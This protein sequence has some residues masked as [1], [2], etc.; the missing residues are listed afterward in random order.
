MWGES[1]GAGSSGHTSARSSDI[2]TNSR[3]RRRLTTFGG[4]AAA[5]LYGPG[6]CSCGVPWAGCKPCESVPVAG[7][8]PWV[9]VCERAAVAK[10]SMDPPAGVNVG[11]AGSRTGSGITPRLGPLGPE[12]GGGGG[13]MSKM[14]SAPNRTPQTRGGRRG[15]VARTRAS[16]AA[17]RRLGGTPQ[18]RGGRRGPVYARLDRGGWRGPAARPRPQAGV[19]AARAEPDGQDT[20]MRISHLRPRGSALPRIRPGSMP[21]HRPH[22]PPH[23]PEPGAAGEE[24][25]GPGRSALDGSGNRACSQTNCSGVNGPSAGASSGVAIGEGEIS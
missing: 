1:V 8:V 19:R 14:I 10:T 22:R 18:T 6:A 21:G 13:W 16:I 25:E 24:V 9:P 23:S 11:M 12:K 2:S 20:C 15:P 5:G 7:S 3:A 4:S 17:A